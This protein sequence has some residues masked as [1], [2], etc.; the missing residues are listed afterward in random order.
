MAAA[1]F[2]ASML[3]I[4][5]QGQRKTIYLTASDV[6][7]AGLVFPSGGTEVSLS[8][9][10]SVIADLNLSAAG[11]DTSN[12][13]VFINGVDT[14]IRIV[15]AANIYSVVTRQVMTAPIA[16]PAGALVKLVQNT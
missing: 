1:P 14:G 9:L 2:K 15:N 13:S 10:N 12:M 11:T 3:V 4:N 16:V 7:A 5:S 8:S 6:N